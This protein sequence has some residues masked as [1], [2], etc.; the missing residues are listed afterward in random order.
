MLVEIIVTN[1]SKP[2]THTHVILVVHPQ[3]RCIRMLLDNT[4]VVDCVNSRRA[5]S[6]YMYN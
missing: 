4:K 5:Q 2:K 1:E 3:C 6:Q